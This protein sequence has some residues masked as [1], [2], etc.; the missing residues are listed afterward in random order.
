M[1]AVNASLGLCGIRTYALQLTSFLRD[2]QDFC[3]ILL[4]GLKGRA[5]C[6][7][8]VIS[9]QLMQTRSLFTSTDLLGGSAA[10]KITA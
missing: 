2:V 7:D 3:G 8:S 4:K 1:A 10:H 5:A 9:Q 6:G